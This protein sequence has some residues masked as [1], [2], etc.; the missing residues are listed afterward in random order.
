MNIKTHT[1]VA[2]PHP[3]AFSSQ[4]SNEIVAHMAVPLF[5]L[6]V[7]PLPPRNLAQSTLSI[8]I[9]PRFFLKIALLRQESLRMMAIEF[10]FEYL[11]QRIYF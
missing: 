5:W 2:A 9:L 3:V 6:H 7:P 8:V 1:I 11:A 4:A 10:S